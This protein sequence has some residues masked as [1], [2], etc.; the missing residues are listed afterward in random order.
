MRVR[1]TECGRRKS[2]CGSPGVRVLG[3][4]KA[5]PRCN[6]SKHRCLHR[7][8]GMAWGGKPA[9]STPLPSPLPPP[10]LATCNAFTRTGGRAKA[11]PRRRAERR[12]RCEHPP[13]RTDTASVVVYTGHG[14]E[15]ERGA[16]SCGAS[17][18]C[19]HA[20]RPLL[21]LLCLLQV[22]TRQESCFFEQ[23]GRQRHQ[24]CSPRPHPVCTH[25]CRRCAKGRR[26]GGCRPTAKAKRP[27]RPQC[28]HG[29][30][31]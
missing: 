23:A 22:A 14:G 20:K 4:I 11:H 3:W 28:G 12:R 21:E 31:R 25:T 15:W 13:G 19:L 26:R 18:Q 6:T 16:T 8:R 9:N 5:R 17:R 7:S 27:C 10:L 30:R 29:R 2:V 1:M 24:H